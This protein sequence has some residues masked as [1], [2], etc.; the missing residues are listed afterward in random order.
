MITAKEL[1]TRARSQM[2]NSIFSNKWLILLAG[3]LVM[4]VL[5]SL[6]G[7][8]AVL[9]LIVVGPVMI[10]LAAAFLKQVRD[11]TQPV[12][13]DDFTYGITDGRLGK[14]VV[15]GLLYTVF[16]F[17]WSLLFFIGG[18]IK[19]YSYS[20]A[21]FISLDH[22]E[23]EAKDVITE[24]RRMMNGHKFRLFCLDLSFIGWYILGL[25]C[26]GIGIL[27]VIPYHNLARANFYD[28][29]V[30]RSSAN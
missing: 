4:D 18:I 7:L 29:L 21:A 8:L 9:S 19:S 15:L 20:M 3:C 23:M 14:S 13:V 16:I 12:V 25:L 30:A 26:F 22:P 27:W 28:D 6:S 10:G 11:N 17:L 5:L 1:R 2:G 24:S